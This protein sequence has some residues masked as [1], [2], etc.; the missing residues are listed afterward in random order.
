M[1]KP[2]KTRNYVQFFTYS[3]I[4]YSLAYLQNYLA[5][6]SQY[7]HK[8]GLKSHPFI[9]Y[10]EMSQPEYYKINKTNLDQLLIGTT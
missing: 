2:A 9:T 7:V 4:Y 5:R 1:K 3:H 8:G 6:F 10:F